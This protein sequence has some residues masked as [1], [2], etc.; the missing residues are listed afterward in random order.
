MS[1]QLLK[2]G[3]TKD[4]CAGVTKVTKKKL[5]NVRSQKASKVTSCCRIPTQGLRNVIEPLIKLKKEEVTFKET[6][7]QVH[8]SGELDGN[9]PRRP[10]VAYP[11]LKKPP[12][13]ETGAMVCT[14]DMMLSTEDKRAQTGAIGSH[15]KE[16]LPEE[17]LHEM[18]TQTKYDY[19][20]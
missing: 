16:H 19:N 5:S 18:T 1:R 17:S 11:D 12:E 4:N 13:T 3:N 9:T 20:P 10:E 14:P 6:Q 2:E 7:K 8:I 15:S